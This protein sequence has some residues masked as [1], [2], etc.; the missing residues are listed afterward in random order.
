MNDEPMYCQSREILPNPRPSFA[1]VPP[2]RLVITSRAPVGL[3]W[4]ARQTMLKPFSNGKM[5]A[6]TISQTNIPEKAVQKNFRRLAFAFVSK[7]SAI[8]TIRI[9]LLVSRIGGKRTLED[10]DGGQ[11]LCI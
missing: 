1:F 9:A 3:L 11:V 2:N 7:W 6:G 8:E 5:Y 10:G 4:V